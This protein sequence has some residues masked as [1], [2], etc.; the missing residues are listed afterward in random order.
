MVGTF[1]GNAQIRRALSG[2]MEMMERTKS[3]PVRK[4]TELPR[5]W[6]RKEGR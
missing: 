5:G 3:H 2:E 6:A 1:R 4:Q